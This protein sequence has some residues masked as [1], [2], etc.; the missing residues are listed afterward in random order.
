MEILTWHIKKQRRIR[1]KI[2]INI[3]IEILEII[4]PDFGDS[5]VGI[6][7]SIY[8]I[9]C[10][11][12]CR[13]VSTGAT[14]ATAVAPKFSD[15]LTLFQPRGADSAHHWHGRTYIFLVVTSLY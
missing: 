1:V 4:K 14:G 3:K 12:V 7:R 11:L 9:V 8:K 2:K 10:T 15:T 6:G 5:C 13:D